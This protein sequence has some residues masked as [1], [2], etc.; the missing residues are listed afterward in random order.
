MQKMSYFFNLFIA[1]T[2]PH[3][4]AAGRAGGMVIVNKSRARSIMN[5]VGTFI[6]IY[7]GTVASIPISAKS[8]IIPTNLI[9]S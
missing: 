4:M 6:L 9:P 8:A 5:I 1:N 3:D 2:M 7:I